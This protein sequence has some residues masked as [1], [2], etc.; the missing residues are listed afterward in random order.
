VP[1]LGLKVLV[2]EVGP[3]PLG[4]RKA[5]RVDLLPGTDADALLDAARP[6]PG[7]RGDVAALDQFIAETDGIGL[8]G[9]V[10]EEPLANRAALR[11]WLGRAGV[12][13]EF[14]APRG[15]ISTIGRVPFRVEAVTGDV[16][17]GRGVVSFCL[18]GPFS[19]R[20]E[21]SQAGMPVDC[22]SA[23]TPLMAAVRALAADEVAVIVHQAPG[24]LMPAAAWLAAL[25]ADPISA[26]TSIVEKNGTVG[27]N[28]LLGLL[29][30]NLYMTGAAAATVGPVLRQAAKDLVA[31][32][33]QG[34]MPQVGEALGGSRVLNVTQEWIEL[35][36]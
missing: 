11:K 28:G 31:L 4:G 19:V 26:W 23:Y 6:L 17:G 30:P 29:L 25:D 1:Q 32:G 14:N 9:V 16:P 7:L 21:R 3:H 2:S 34:R 36:P 22:L 10:L 8:L 20:T 12:P 15:P 5:T 33:Q 27:L 18:S 13:L 24:C 35:A